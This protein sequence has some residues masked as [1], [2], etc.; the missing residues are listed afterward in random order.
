M[1][2]ELLHSLVVASSALQDANRL[3][4]AADRE[5]ICQLLRQ[6]AWKLAAAMADV[7]PDSAA[8]EGVS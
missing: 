4:R 3:A 8:P 1:N 6:A 7:V 5:D 2:S